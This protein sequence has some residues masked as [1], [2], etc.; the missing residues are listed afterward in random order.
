MQVA[1]SP[2]PSSPDGV[3]LRE[4]ALRGLL[5]VLALGA[6]T[7]QR[8]RLEGQP[9][10]YF[11]VAADAVREVPRAAIRLGECYGDPGGCATYCTQDPITCAATAPDA[12]QLAIFDSAAP[13]AMFAGEAAGGD[14]DAVRTCFELRSSPGLTNAPAGPDPDAVARVRLLD[15]PAMR[16]SRDSGEAWSWELG[17]DRSP[18]QHSPVVLGG[19]LLADFAV[20]FKDPVD[21]PSGAV[22]V[23][24]AP[25]YVGSE[26]SLADTGSVYLRLQYPSV[27][28]GGQLDDQCQVG[29]SD[30]DLGEI[31]WSTGQWRSLLQPHR[32]IVDACVAAPPCAVAFDRAL[33]PLSADPQCHLAPRRD[34][35][36]S[37]ADATDPERGGRRATMVVA[38][39]MPGA[40]L[41]EDSAVQILGD[42]SDLPECGSLPT[43]VPDTVR[44]CTESTA[45]SLSSPGWPRLDDLAVLRVRS[46][47]LVSGN[48]GAQGPGACERLE[49][50]L[51][52]LQR[53]C[54]RTAESRAPWKP[55][56]TPEDETDEGAIVVGEVQWTTGDGPDPSAWIRTIILPSASALVNFTRRDTGTDAAQI[57]GFI[58][59]ALLRHS[60]LVLDY[61]EEE[62]PPG[63][64]FRCL[65]PGDG[66][67]LS[68]PGCRGSEGGRGE[69]GTAS[70]CHGLP[71]SLLSDIILPSDSSFPPPPRAEDTCCVALAPGVRDQLEAIAPVCEGQPE[72][73]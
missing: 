38:S 24:L 53:Q 66:R 25:D 36:S 44:A 3:A 45:G 10:V 57:D 69:P 33:G 32:L 42:L 8:A 48:E 62:R 60:E 67:C 70:C 68:I 26:G 71:Q 41:I 2:T 72:I 46:V 20:S 61:T 65:D 49:R 43:P 73:R 27:L 14:D 59:S 39:A 19:S 56:D 40:A 7:E 21:G 22:Q 15:A 28:A 29:S 13:F 63:V 50:R 1:R 51:Q 23:A 58:G 12:C 9:G 64:R 5:G 17:D 30:C 55:T 54:E 52:G 4:L 37:C 31:E 6:C 47:A 35:P 16:V 18:T 11:E 34:D